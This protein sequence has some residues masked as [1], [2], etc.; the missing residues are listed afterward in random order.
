VRGRGRVRRGRTGSVQ[1]CRRVRPRRRGGDLSQ[2]SAPQLR[3]LRRGAVLHAR[4]RGAAALRRGRGARGHDGLRG[5]V[6]PVGPDGGAGSRR[7]R[8][9]RQHQ[10]QP[11]PRGPASGTGADAGHPRRRRQLRARLRQPRGWSGRARLRRGFDGVRRGG[12]AGGC[13]AAVRRGRPRRRSRAA[14]SG[15]WTRGGGRRANPCPS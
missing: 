15:C 1:R 7:S 11:L 12:D 5:R 4:H 6:E 8:A 3:R 14:R 13:R 9:R 10:R 2:A